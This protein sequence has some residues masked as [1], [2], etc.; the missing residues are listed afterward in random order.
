MILKEKLSS[1]S[2]IIYDAILRLQSTNQTT[3]ET[4]NISRQSWKPEL[5]ATMNYTTVWSLPKLKSIK[6]ILNCISVICC[7]HYVYCTFLCLFLTMRRVPKQL[8]NKTIQVTLKTVKES[9]FSSF[10]KLWWIVRHKFHNVGDYRVP[11]L[12]H[13]NFIN[14]V[15]E[16]SVLGERIQG[17]VMH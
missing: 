1:P 17:Y 7:I 3:H 6:I 10:I 16:L 15:I 13:W 2:N 14:A 8:C 12:G 4:T 9:K 5:T 11:C